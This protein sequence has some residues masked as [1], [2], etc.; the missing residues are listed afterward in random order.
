MSKSAK[1][2]LG[3][4]AGPPSA[5]SFDRTYLSIKCDASGVPQLEETLVALGV[6]SW[7]FLGELPD[8]TWEDTVPFLLR[9]ANDRAEL[10]KIRA[11]AK[12]DVRQS[13]AMELHSIDESGHDAD[14]SQG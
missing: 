12:S 9:L 3:K 5:S 11:E 8:K 1:K 4:T 14:E 2:K 10:D 6:H 13:R 7:Q